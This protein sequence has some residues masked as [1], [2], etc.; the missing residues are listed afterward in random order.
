M[1]QRIQSVTW[2][3][4]KNRKHPIRTEREKENP[5]T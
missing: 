4:K 5:K 2:K 1:K 3:I